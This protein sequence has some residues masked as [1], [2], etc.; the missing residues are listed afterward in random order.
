MSKLLLMAK[1]LRKI[2]RELEN[3]KIAAAEN[4][5]E[6]E[7]AL[8]DLINELRPKL[9]VLSG[10]PAFGK[11][12]PLLDLQNV[13]V[14]NPQMLANLIDEAPE[15]K[16]DANEFL[17]LLKKTRAKKNFPSIQALIKILDFAIA[18]KSE[19]TKLNRLLRQKMLLKKFLSE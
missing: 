13:R 16:V 10:R 19:P 3:H 14:R 4:D 1:N 2:A 12:L 15:Q 5:D 17:A 8:N 6:E 18:N 7:I 9:M 11:L